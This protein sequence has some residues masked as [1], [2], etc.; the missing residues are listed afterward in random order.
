MSKFF[1]HAP[2]DK[3]LG[4]IPGLAQVVSPGKS[5]GKSFTLDEPGEYLFYCGPHREEGMNGRLVV[6]K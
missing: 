6:E 2:G 5:A 4:G 1:L 3:Y